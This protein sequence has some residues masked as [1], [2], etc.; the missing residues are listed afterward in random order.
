MP[1]LT[2]FDYAIIRVVPRVERGEFLNVG[3]VLFC[4]TLRFLGSRIELDGC[5]LHALAPKLDLDSL[6]QHLDSITAICVGGSTAGPIGQ[7]PIAERFHWL[8]SP[9]STII[10]PSPVHCGICTDAQ[11]ALDQVFAAM[12]HLPPLPQSQPT[13]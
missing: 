1:T 8:V 7:L 10:Q 12:V 13:A 2:T 3:V 6:Q 9:R 11:A 5:R 4:R